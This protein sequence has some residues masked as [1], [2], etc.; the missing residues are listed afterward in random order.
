MKLKTIV[1]PIS[2]VVLGFIIMI[3]L[4]TLRSDPPKSVAVPRTKIVDI[5]VTTL[6][7]IHTKIT[8]LGRVASAQPLVLYSEV[9]G[10]LMRGNVP[11][12]PAQFFNKGDLVIK[13]DDRQI[14]LDIK[15]AIS[16]FLNALSS[17]LPEIKVDF[18]EEFQIWQDYFNNCNFD[19]P[20]PDLPHTENQK[21][22]LF[23]SRFNV[24]KLYFTVRNLEIKLEKHYF[25]APFT[26][27]IVS[28]DLRVGAITRN[29][30]RIGEVINLDNLEVEIP[31]PAEDIKWIDR[32]KPVNLISKEL[33][34]EWNENIARVGNTIDTKTQSVSLYARLTAPVARDIISGIYLQASIPGRTIKNAVSVPRKAIY[35]DN[36]VYLIKDGRLDYQMVDI[37]RKETNS[38]IVTA[39]IQTGDTL[40]IEVLQGVAGGMLAGPKESDTTQRSN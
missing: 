36:Y 18:P 2:I 19:S 23:L 25:Y 13:I 16:D 33:N 11:F 20:L 31:V 3:G 34:R 32:N 9:P 30:T 6:E 22:R 8:A 35:E 26:G 24:Y 4:F 37:A 5:K 38:V 15:S 28:T 17:V 21:I 12:R 27:S 29:G 40:V 10:T 7:D 39:G 1:I 14:K